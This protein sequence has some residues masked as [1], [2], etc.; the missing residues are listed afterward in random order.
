MQ[1]KETT[2][3]YKREYLAPESSFLEFIPMSLI[4]ASNTEAI[5]EDPTEY[6]WDPTT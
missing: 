4:A 3:K 1:R 6:P 5:D 2:P